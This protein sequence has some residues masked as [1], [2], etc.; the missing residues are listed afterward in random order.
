MSS[1]IKGYKYDAGYDIILDKDIV[2]EPHSTKVI[3]L[4]IIFTPKENEMGFVCSRTSA[5]AKGLIV[6]QCPI[7]TDF[8]GTISAIVHNVSNNTIEYKEGEAFC[9]LVVTPIILPENID[10]KI[11]KEGRRGSGKFGST[12]GDGR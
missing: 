10:C 5:A 2:F 9:Q 1:F 3:D 6:S 12:G 7:D 8:N 4:G 11:K